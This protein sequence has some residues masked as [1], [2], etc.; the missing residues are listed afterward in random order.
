MKEKK[1]KV[2]MIVQ[3][4]MV[5]GGIA[6]V[7]NGYYGSKLEQDYDMIYVESYKDGGKLTKL[8]KG[9]CGYFHFAKV[10]LFSRPDIVHMHS[11]FG[12]SFYRS[13][14][15][16]Y[17]ASWAKKPMINH[18]HGAD[19]DEF[20]VQASE[21]KKKLIKRAYSKCAVLI[22]LSAEWKERLLRIVPAEK[23]AIIENYSILHEDALRD[24]LERKSNNT[25]LFLGEI[26]KRKGCYDIPAVVAE[27]VKAVPKVKFIIGGVGSQ[28]DEQAV[29]ALFEKYGVSDHVVFPGWVRGDD[30]DR[31]LREAD[32]FF[33]PSYNEGMP[34]SVLD[35]MGYGLPVVSTNVGG[36]PKIVHNG[37][38]G[39][40]CEAGDTRNMAEG[41]ITILSD[42]KALEKK[43]IKSFEIVM[44]GYSLDSHLKLIED[45]YEKCR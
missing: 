3:D 37:E 29:K 38:N 9:I 21:K 35:A 11:S 15:F 2:C 26:G 16:I 14:P 40:C 39:C 24:R 7:I 36:I 23:I 25:V 41:I 33:L 18:I 34:M 10:L 27:V 1:T 5:K 6:A 32:V 43:S 8:W 42:R 45:V 20:Y 31:F 19:F 13:L 17:M 28:T 44:T 12:P 22:A 4:K 30:K